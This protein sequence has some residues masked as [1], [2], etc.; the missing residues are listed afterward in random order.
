[1]TGEQNRSTDDIGKAESVRRSVLAGPEARVA[2]CRNAGNISFSEEIKALF[3]G[4]ADA[5]ARTARPILRAGGISAQSRKAVNMPVE[6]EKADKTE[7]KISVII[8]C[9]NVERYIDRCIHSL[10][11]QTIGIE[12]LQLIFVDDASTDRTARKLRWWQAKYPDSVEIYSLPEN[13][14]Q[15]GARNEG[16]KHASA[17]A[18]G[19]VDSDDWTAP[20]MFER[21]YGALLRENC[22]FVNCCAKRAFD[23]SEPLNPRV[24]EDRRIDV[25]TE[26]ERRQFLLERLPG[27]IYCRLFKREF[28]EK[29][30]PAFPEQTAYEDNYW[31]AMVKLAAQSCYVLGSEL[32]YYFVNPESTILSADSKRHLERL[33]VEEAKLEEYRRRGVLERYYREFEVEFLRLYYINS[34]HTFFLRMSKMNGLPFDRMQRAVKENFPDYLSSPYLGRFSALETELLK[35]AEQEL[36]AEQWQLLAE[37][38]RR[39][40]RPAE[41]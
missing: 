26:E 37:G 23:A 29:Q 17:D 24:C 8:P 3:R 10:A 34:L 21:L 38:Y 25:H 18:V 27:G 35:T 9:Y 6:I 13:R 28:L 22:D 20:D 15:G 4:S 19:F 2:R 5:H 7:K 11:V 12:H 39:L 30:I 16:L 31:M 41:N 33:A 14:R 1:M 40:Y 32:Y 36:T